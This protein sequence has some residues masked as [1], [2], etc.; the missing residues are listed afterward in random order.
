MPKPT[1]FI[2]NFVKAIKSIYIRYEMTIADIP[3]AYAVSEDE[4]TGEIILG[5]HI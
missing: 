2:Y 3:I 5:Q 1:D 4:E